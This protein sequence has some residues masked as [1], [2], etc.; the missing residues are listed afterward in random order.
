[1]ILLNIIQSFSAQELKILET[2]LSKNLNSPLTSSVG[3][4]FDGI[5]ALLGIIDQV[6]FEGQAAMQLEFAINDLQTN[7]AYPFNW[8]YNPNSCSYIDWRL[9]I[10][11]IIK[12]YLSK[13]SLSLISA[14]FHLT[15]VQ[16]ITIVARKIEAKNVILSGGCF[17]NKYLLENAISYLS[18]T[19]FRPYWSQEVPLNDGGLVLG[20]IHFA[21]YPFSLSRRK[22]L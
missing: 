5:S 9:I 8:Q 2:M 22:S 11:H 20:Q 14:K 3:R 12:D 16:I 4:L 10:Q 17:Q 13:Q 6:T 18:R 1:M 21:K 19:K 15:L 7:E